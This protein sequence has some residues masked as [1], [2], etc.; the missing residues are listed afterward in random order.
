MWCTRLDR[1]RKENSKMKKITNTK[2][3]TTKAPKAT[4]AAG[5]E[6]ELGNAQGITINDSTEVIKPTEEAR[7]DQMK[8]DL[9]KLKAGDKKRKAAVKAA[10]PAK[11]TPA[12]KK[13]AKPA[14]A[15]A[16][17]AKA[18]KQAKVAKEPKAAG[19]SKKDQVLALISRK[20]GAS[21]D[22]IMTATGWQKHTVRGFIAILGKKGTKIESFKSEAGART[23]K[24]A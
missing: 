9:T 13:A 22:E 10:K 7:Q 6:P 1:G 5:T 12:A 18:P 4:T 2:A 16:K 3:K 19:T 17:P 20:N 15:T 23:Y 21:L 14:K 24:A 8:S 11:A